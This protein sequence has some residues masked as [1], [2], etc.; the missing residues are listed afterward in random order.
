VHCGAQAG[1]R[2]QRKGASPRL[3]R[4]QASLLCS[5]IRQASELPPIPLSH[6]PQQ[7]WSLELEGDTLRTY[8]RVS[9][10]R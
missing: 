1:G 9:D 5:L 3:H 7:R 8:Q 2:G 4:E 6:A 10:D